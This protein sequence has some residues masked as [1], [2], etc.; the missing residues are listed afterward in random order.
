MKKLILALLTLALHECLSAQQPSEEM[1]QRFMYRVSFA[2]EIGY[3]TLVST[4]SEREIA[5]SRDANEIAQISFTTGIAAE[6]AFTRNWSLSVGFAYANRGYQTK[7][8][9]FNWSAP[10]QQSP[11]ESY[12]S[13]R[14]GYIDIPILLTYR[15]G[16]DRHWTFFATGGAVPSV[17]LV[18]SKTLFVNEQNTWASTDNQRGIGYDRFAL[19]LS[20]EVGAEYTL[21]DSF[22][23]RLGIVGKRAIAASN[24]NM[25]TQ[26]YLFSGGLNLGFVWRP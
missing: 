1:P 12:V 23:L 20:A 2:P 4:A 13:Y 7:T 26:E 8:A 19:F 3:R 10:A 9:I 17:F 18:R 11:S 25:A 15:F 24:P 5:E 16:H 14:F 21:S 6:Y 22:A